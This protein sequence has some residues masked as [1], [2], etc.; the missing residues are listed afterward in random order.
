MRSAF[1][2]S[3]GHFCTGSFCWR[4][5]NQ[6]ATGDAVSLGVASV[7][8]WPAAFLFRGYGAQSAEVALEREVE[9]P[10]TLSS[11]NGCGIKSNTQQTKKPI[12]KNPARTGQ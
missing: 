11:R 10:R 9:A 12:T 6:R 1:K 2:R 3:A 4:L 8:F 7:V 5:Q